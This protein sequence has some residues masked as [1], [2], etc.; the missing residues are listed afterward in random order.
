MNTTTTRLQH[1]RTRKGTPGEGCC[2]CCE[3]RWGGRCCLGQATGR[4]G[5]RPVEGKEVLPPGRGNEQGL[6]G[7]CR[8][9]RLVSQ[10]MSVSEH[11]RVGRRDGGDRHGWTEG[12]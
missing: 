10:T 2:L 3:L 5:K 12:G 4:R 8:I 9:A 1:T 6:K 7:T 11:E